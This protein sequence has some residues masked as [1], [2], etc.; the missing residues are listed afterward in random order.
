MFNID[1]SGLGK[2]QNDLRNTQRALESLNGTITSLKFDR[3]DLKSVEA[4]IQQ[5]EAA[6]DNKIACYRNNPF[7]SNIAKD[8]KA[9]YRQQILDCGRS[10]G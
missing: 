8:M 6:I 3:S 1:I 7:V 10:E 4:A 2:L 5:M 9:K